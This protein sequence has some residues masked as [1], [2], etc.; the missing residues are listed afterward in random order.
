MGEEDDD[1][2]IE[3]GESSQEDEEEE[4][5]EED[6]DDDEEEEEEDD[7]GEEEAEEGA[8]GEVT[9][10]EEA[11]KDAKE[12]EEGEVEGGEGE[13][14]DKEGGN[15]SKEGAEEKE[16]K[17]KE[18]KDS[19][20]EGSSSPKKVVKKKKKVVAKKTKT[21]KT[22][23]SKEGKKAAKDESGG[24]EKDGE[25]KHTLTNF[26][27]HPYIKLRCPHCHFACVTFKEYSRHLG[28][29]KHLA[30]MSTLSAKLRKTFVTMRLDQRKMQKV[31]DEEAKS[32]NSR[33]RTLFCSICKLNYRTLK[34]QHQSSLSH[35]KMK[36]FQSPY[37]R[38][39]RITYKSA[40]AYE[41]HVCELQHIKRKARL[42][43]LSKPPG[44][45]DLDNSD[46]NLDTNNFM[47]LDAVG[48]GDDSEGEKSDNEEK[49][50]KSEETKDKSKLT[51]EK[52]KK[53]EIK[54][55][56][57]S[58][59]C[60]L[61]EVYFCELCKIYLPRLDDK[62]RALTVHCRSRTHLQ[63]Y[64][65][66]RDDRTLRR[67]AVRLHK[68]REK[69]KE[70]AKEKKTSKD[71]SKSTDENSAEKMEEGGDDKAT[72]DDSKEGENEDKAWSE[73]DKD[74]SCLLNEEEVSSGKQRSD[75]DDEE[76]ED[77]EE[78]KEG[79]R[80]DRF[81]H[82]EKDKL[83]DES[84]AGSPVI[85]KQTSANKA[86]ST[87]SGSTVKEDESVDIA[88]TA[89]GSISSAEKKKIEAAE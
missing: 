21:T 63:R 56:Q 23:E 70:K 60:K 33:L 50:E 79:E 26:L 77:D 29:A 43:R 17:D 28:T 85:E 13:E 40:W 47:V 12:A 42:E 24:E 59:F 49:G 67:K 80:Y 15:S 89:N 36:E 11:S 53:K 52:K 44:S 30:A 45:K 75:E 16:S 3:V 82:S 87:T 41:Q 84:L 86:K 22:S 27:G 68:E 32:V 5:E 19:S 4:E 55:G 25:K 37:C 9:K 1:E 51:K 76:E 38:V 62:D 8:E 7:E 6:E 39:C 81:K 88:N 46:I 31:L 61:V 66:S 54:L 18:A 14:K 72:K 10:D 34:S 74:L 48:S 78:S 73:V 2:V 57:G 69:L 58:E 65:R 64:I 35:R 71:D 83:K 20:K